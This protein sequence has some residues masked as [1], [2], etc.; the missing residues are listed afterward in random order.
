MDT[1]GGITA[2]SHLPAGTAASDFADGR[3]RCA[4]LAPNDR[5]YQRYHDEEWGVPLHDDRA[6]F[7][8]LILEGF[9]AGL[10]WRTVLH[11]RDRFRLVFDGFDPELVAAFDPARIEQLMADTGIIRNRLKINAAVTNARSYLV[12]QEQHGS[13][14]KYLWSFVGDKRI[15]NHWS[16]ST[17]VPA[18]T[19]LSDAL[20]RD[21]R[22]RG[23]K[24]TGS[25]IMY[26]YLQ[27]AGVVQDH[28]TSCYRHEELC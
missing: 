4:W 11:K 1:N 27:A 26:A 24:F 7:E 21:L 23:F 20:S 2:N 5:L 22:A 10:S 3:Q 25:T 9:Q 28:L 12:V 19:E 6:L 16:D 14:S 8:L 17:Q 13:F 15:V 18:R